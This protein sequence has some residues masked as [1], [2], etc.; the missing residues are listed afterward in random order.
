M[1]HRFPFF[2]MGCQTC[3]ARVHC[4]EC[5]ERLSQMLMRL[6]GINGAV[7]QMA[8]KQLAIDGDLDSGTL[9]GTLE[10]LGIFVG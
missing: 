10:D 3:Q 8:N 6:E 2:Y 4:E 5:E 7:V 1:T 9:E